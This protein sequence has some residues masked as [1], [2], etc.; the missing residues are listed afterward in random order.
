MNNIK[1]TY[2]V[3]FV[4]VCSDNL[5]EREFEKEWEVTERVGQERG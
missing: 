3:I 5:K 4:C 1:L 2:Q